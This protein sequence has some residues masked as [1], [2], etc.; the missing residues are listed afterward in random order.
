[1]TLYDPHLRCWPSLYLPGHNID[2]S[3]DGPDAPISITITVM[4][5]ELGFPRIKGTI[6]HPTYAAACAAA[7][8]TVKELQAHGS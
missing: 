6:A 1:M 2:F 3:A 7:V 4:N 8:T 5:H